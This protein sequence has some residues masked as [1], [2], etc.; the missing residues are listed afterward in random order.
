MF[1][2]TE[3]GES[4]NTHQRRQKILKILCLRKHEKICNLASE[5]GVSERTISRDIVA[6]SFEAPIYTVPGRYYGGVYIDKSFSLSKL[7]FNDDEQILLK[8]I[9]TEKEQKSFCKLT[10]PELTKLKAIISKYSKPKAPK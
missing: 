8:K 5:L 1:V 3:K 2:K 4:M 9:A 7:Y 6:L 10:E